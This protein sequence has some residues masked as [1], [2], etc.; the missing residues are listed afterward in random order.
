MKACHVLPALK[1]TTDQWSLIILT[2]FLMA[3]ELC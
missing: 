3:K 1:I 2:G